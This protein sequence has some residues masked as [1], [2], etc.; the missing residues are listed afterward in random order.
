MKLDL[1]FKSASLYIFAGITNSAIPFMLLPI[2][3]RVLPPSEYGKV[4]MFSSVLVVLSAFVGL[5]VHGAVSVKYFDP[6][7]D[8]PRYLATSLMVL[9]ASTVFAV[10]IIIIFN[11]HLS[12]N[13]G[14][15]LEWMIV[16]VLASAAQFVVQLRLLMWQISHNALKYGIF[17][18][19]QTA[20]NIAIS[21]FFVLCLNYGWTGRGIGIASS[22]FIFGLISLLSMQTSGMI[23]WKLSSSYIISMLKFGI[24][25]IPH[26]VGGLLMSTSDR[27]TIS[28]LLGVEEA[29]I[30][31]AAMQV[32]MIVVV[33]SDAC[34][35]SFAPWLF[36][37]LSNNNESDKIQ[38]VRYTYILFVAIPVLALL[39]GW[40]APWLLQFVVGPQYQKSS[41]SVLYI[42]LGGGFGAMYCLV[43]NYIF[44]AEKTFLLALVSI[45]SG[46]VNVIL[47]I[48]LVK[49]G[50]AIGAAQAYMVSQAFYFVFTWIIAANVFSMPWQSVLL[51]CRE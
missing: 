14:I 3:T 8:H 18:V 50:G 16:A 32:G 48:M 1:L 30:Y 38:I 4:V 12:R 34:N 20:I 29:G 2:L 24:P 21:L 23:R 39:F 51:G 15:S 44:Y 43:V 37:I 10:L 49:L 25:L 45:L 28:S 35:K 5:S 42:A 11:E 22:M 7:I 36:K 27:F 17:L 33:I 40:M 47:A 46:I 13:I 31:A 26:S 9:V 41:E 19:S 6:S